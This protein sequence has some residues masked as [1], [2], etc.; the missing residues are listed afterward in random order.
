MIYSIIV[1]FNPQKDILKQS[2]VNIKSDVD[3][4]LLV[5]NSPIPQKLD[6]LLE[7]ESIEYYYNG[8]LNGIAGAQNIGIKKFRESTYDYLLILDQDSIPF[9]DMVNELYKNN[10]LLESNN[11]KVACIGP[12]E[13]E[14]LTNKLNILKVSDIKSSGA[15]FTKKI[16]DVVGL[17]EEDLFIDAVDS[18]WCWRAKKNGYD[19]FIV[20][21]AK[22]VHQY[23]E[24]NKSIL[25][26]SV[27]ITAPFRT[28]YQYRNYLFMLIRGYVPLSWKVKNGFK[29]IFKFFLYPILTRDL[30]Y[31][32]YIFRGIYHGIINK[33]GA[34]S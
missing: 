7:D 4:I 3:R 21:S 6:D 5:D 25:G 19:S 14:G 26:I 9:P 27:A 28:Y 13:K 11:T 2:I 30:R 32:K 34:F 17:M 22:M 15:F 10:L 18:E 1:L 16:F 20:E 33:K 29:Y 12:S 23:G 8:N 31:Y 24:G